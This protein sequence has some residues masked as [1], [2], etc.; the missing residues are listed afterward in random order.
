MNIRKDPKTRRKLLDSIAQREF[1]ERIGVHG[2][3]LV[4][5][6][7]K[8]ALRKLCPAEQTD[9]ETLIFSLGWST[10][11]WLTG[12]FDPEAEYTI[13]GITITPDSDIG[14]CPWEL[15]ATYQSSSRPIEENVHWIRQIM[16]QC[17]V[18]DSTVATLSRLE[19]MGDWGWVFGRKGLTKE[20][21]KLFKK[22]SKHPT[23]SAYILE[24]SKE[25][26]D[27]HWEW[28]K[29][30]RDLYVKILETRQLQ[31]KIIALASGS[32]WE[33]DYCTYREKCEGELK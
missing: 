22:Q 29:Q 24:F 23:L 18:T 13:D 7:N 28:M 8:Q 10:Q 11:R 26:L 1:H 15:K 25:E 33:C 9:E 6:L 21:S 3:D 32:G 30:R 12:T 20:E 5:C 4:Y 16:S 27:A 2:S 14:G 19:I 31:P 17:C